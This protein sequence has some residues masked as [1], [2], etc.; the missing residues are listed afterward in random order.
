MYPLLC[1][2]PALT[3]AHVMTQCSSGTEGSGADV[4][5]RAWL[6]FWEVSLRCGIW[7]SRKAGIFTGMWW[8]GREGWDETVSRAVLLTGADTAMCLC[9]E[10]FPK[11]VIIT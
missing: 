10:F 9:K 11:P 8:W 5:S 3:T 7:E 1:G 6:R 4:E 2:P